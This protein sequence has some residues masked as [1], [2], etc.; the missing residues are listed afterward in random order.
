MILTDVGNAREAAGLS[1]RTVVV[2]PAYPDLM[3]LT[4]SLVER[5]S[6]TGDV[7]NLE[8][9]ATAMASMMDADLDPVTASNLADIRQYVSVER[10]VDAYYC[11][12]LDHQAGWRH[13]WTEPTAG[14]F[15]AKAA[16]RNSANDSRPSSRSRSR[17]VGADCSA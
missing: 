3:A 1:D 5:L 17:S 14:G 16:R 6:R 9:V 4:P 11:H 13:L 10:M 15:G 12:F 7:Q 8:A 2:P